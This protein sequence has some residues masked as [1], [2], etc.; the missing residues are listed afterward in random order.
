M[1]YLVSLAILILSC[2]YIVIVLPE[3]FPASKRGELRLQREEDM[4]PISQSWLQR[5][6]SLL[7]I[8][9]EPL[10]QLKP[11]Y[12]PSTGRYNRRLLYCAIHIF[13]VTLADGYAVL[14]MILYFTTHY[15]YTP[16][17]VSLI[18]F[19]VNGL[20]LLICPRLDMF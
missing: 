12:D 18:L 20:R 8:M 3:S 7:V 16:A 19:F 2:L 14:S 10:Q 15:K 1:V 17:Q 11:K 9:V 6:Q 5:V 13:I 4:P